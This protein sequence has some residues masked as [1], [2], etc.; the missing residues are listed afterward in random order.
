MEL[1]KYELPDNIDLLILDNAYSTQNHIS[2]ML[3]QQYEKLVI[4]L[5]RNILKRE[6]VPEDAKDLNMIYRQGIHGVHDVSYKGYKIGTITQTLDFE[7]G[8]L[9]WRFDPCEINIEKL[10]K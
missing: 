1:I 7:K 8:S 6:P 4:E 3:V 9:G 2:D 5:L 10:R